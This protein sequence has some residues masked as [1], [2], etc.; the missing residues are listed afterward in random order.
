ML[1]DVLERLSVGPGTPMRDVV[2]VIDLAE[3]QLALVVDD[4]AC[5][6]GTISD[7]DV[8]RA[9]LRGM[10]LDDTAASV[11]NPA[12]LLVGLGTSEA[13]I[14][15]L[16]Q[17]TGLRRIPVVDAAGSL[18]GLAVPRSELP[19]QEME[20]QVVIMAGGLGTR[21]AE[22]T[23]DR[24]KPLLDV[25][26]KPM[27]E[28]IIERFV[29]Q[30]FTR[31]TISVNYKAEMIK[32]KFGDGSSYGANISYIHENKRMGTA[33]ALQLL[34]HTPTEPI[35]VVNGDVLTTV[36][37]RRLLGF[38]LEAGAAATVGV[39]FHDV[40]VPYGVV[41]V[42]NHKVGSIVEKPV[43]RY[44]VNAGIYVLEQRCLGYLPKDEYFDM[45]SLLEKLLADGSA[46]SSYPI[47]EYW[48][49]VGRKADYDRANLDYEKV[50][51]KR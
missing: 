22:L 6:I 30:G 7:G 21:L 9:L 43:Y 19:A 3:L 26:P 1:T 18:V 10:K 27:L 17:R 47:H 14:E 4:D 34:P 35:I 24:P 29:R 45:T 5:L 28:T 42:E 8:R 44:F 39:T 16:M 46:V 50:F 41:T 13:A 23:K 40:Q 31:I 32:E 36:D 33:G 48:Q 12:P 2:E 15:A 11:M 51:D 37:F 49:D 20:N 38:H 25:G